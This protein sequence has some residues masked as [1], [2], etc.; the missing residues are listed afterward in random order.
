MP[1]LSP[2]A[3]GRVSL[4]VIGDTSTLRETRCPG[5]PLPLTTDPARVFPRWSPD[6]TGVPFHLDPEG[7]YGLGCTL[8]PA[9]AASNKRSATC[10][11]AFSWLSHEPALVFSTARRWPPFAL[12]TLSVESGALNPTFPPVRQP[13]GR[14]R[15]AE[16]TQAVPLKGFLSFNNRILDVSPFPSLVNPWRAKESL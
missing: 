3:P 5:R 13:I 9:W 6:G 2:D 11:S 12:Y 7:Y 4:D 15:V 16:G 8:V 10:R 14:P 1:S